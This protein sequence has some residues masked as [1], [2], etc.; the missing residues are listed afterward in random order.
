VHVDERCVLTGSRKAGL[1]GGFD[2]SGPL[3][4][5]NS[6]ADSQD[7]LAAFQVAHEAALL[8]HFPAFFYDS[9]GIK[10]VP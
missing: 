6:S 8:N 7:R 2:A 10:P 3:D 5:Q 9:M 4:S 1:G